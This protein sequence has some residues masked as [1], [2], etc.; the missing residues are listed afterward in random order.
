MFELKGD[1]KIKVS[2]GDTFV[3]NVISSI[4]FKKGDTVTLTVKDELD[5]TKTVIEK[6]VTEFKDVE[7]YESGCCCNVNTSKGKFGGL[8]RFEFSSLDTSKAAGTYLYDI[9]MDFKERG[10]RYTAMWPTKFII[11]EDVTNNILD[12]AELVPPMMGGIE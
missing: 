3:L 12:M 7:V 8:A 6:V 11:M 5:D 2:Q 10:I 1:G 4:P 9:Q